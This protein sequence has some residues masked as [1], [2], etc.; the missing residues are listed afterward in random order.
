MLERLGSRYWYPLY[1]F[2]RKRGYSSHDAQDLT[3]GFFST[4]LKRDGL[5]GID[6]ERG[7]FRSYLLGAMDHYLCEV[8]RGDSAQKRGGGKPVLSIDLELA[9]QRFGNE[10]AD[11]LTPE[12]LFDREW[13][14]ALLAE[15]A[16]RLRGEYV[17][18]GKGEVFDVLGDYLTARPD[19]GTYP[20]IAG[21]LG[22][23][24]GNVRVMVNRLR[25]R[26]QSLLRETIGELV[27]SEED[28]AEELSHLFAA[29]SCR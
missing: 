22:V 26:Y 13:A 23:N 11:A 12:K 18:R 24:E 15:V 10:P 25:K 2:L 14:L 4:M 21:E 7:R 28:I 8:R 19:K 3:Q 1:A 9:E 27:N 5:V 29:F 16:D 20:R 17:G 6:R